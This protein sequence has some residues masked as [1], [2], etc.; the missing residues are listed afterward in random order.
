MERDGNNSNSMSA[1]NYG[2]VRAGVS[3]CGG[4]ADVAV[5]APFVVKTYRMVNDPATDSV[6]TWGK[7]NNTFIVMDPF[8]FSQTLLP[9]HF[10][11][12]NFSSFVRQLNTYVGNFCIGVCVYIY[13]QIKFLRTYPE[14]FVFNSFVGLRG[15]ELEQY[16]FWS[17]TTRY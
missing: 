3:N 15:M 8:V 9:A 6:I 2:F 1:V 10:K 17:C 7:D 4:S 5:A 14:F 13:I 12:S 11:H 16:Y